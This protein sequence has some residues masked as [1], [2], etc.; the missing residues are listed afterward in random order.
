MAGTFVRQEPRR[1]AAPGDERADALAREWLPKPRILRPWPKQRF[2]VKHPRWEPDAL[3]GLVR[4]H[5]GALS[6]ERPYRDKP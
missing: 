4:F 5:A 6:N 3:I 1:E 2:A